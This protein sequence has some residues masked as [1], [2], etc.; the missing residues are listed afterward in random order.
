MKKGGCVIWEILSAVSLAALLTLG[1]WVLLN[2]GDWTNEFQASAGDTVTATGNLL[3]AFL[4]TIWEL[5]QFLLNAIL[6]FAGG[7]G[8]LI[9]LVALLRPW[10]AQAQFLLKLL[11]VVV[12]VTGLV[13]MVSWAGNVFL[14][15]ITQVVNWILY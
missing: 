6:W 8:S 11:L 7:L 5:I 14:S 4:E 13:A 2:I 1:V 10:R 12:F 3:A 9:I 15:G